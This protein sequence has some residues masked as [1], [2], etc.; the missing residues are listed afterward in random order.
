V[1]PTGEGAG[2]IHKVNPLSTL[3][4]FSVTGWDFS[5]RA[6]C[7]QLVIST[8]NVATLVSFAASDAVSSLP[9]VRFRPV[10]KAST[11][12][13]MCQKR[14]GEKAGGSRQQSKASVGVGSGL[15]G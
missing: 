12:A 10:D 15:V 13:S 6:T 5:A 8:S 14:K 4:M 11:K 2:I 9:L 1:L 3:A 7:L